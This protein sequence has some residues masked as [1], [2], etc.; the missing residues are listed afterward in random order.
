M[1]HKGIIFALVVGVIKG[2]VHFY[3]KCFIKTHLNGV[4]SFLQGWGR[5]VENNTAPPMVLPLP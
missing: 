4:L 5:S 2:Y 1:C 3:W